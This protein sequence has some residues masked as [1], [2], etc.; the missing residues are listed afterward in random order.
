MQFFLFWNEMP[1]G[2]LD[3]FFNC[4][5]TQLNNFQTITQS[6]LNILNIIR[7]SNE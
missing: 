5:T 6:R 7:G 2:D 1:F 3:F 4:I